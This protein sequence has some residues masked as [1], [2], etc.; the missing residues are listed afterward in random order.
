MERK[1]EKCISNLIDQEKDEHYKSI[2]EK[3][4]NAYKNGKNIDLQDIF[5]YLSKR[6]GVEVSC[7]SVNEIITLLTLYTLDTTYFCNRRVPAEINVYLRKDFL[8][9]T[10]S[11][12]ADLTSVIEE[13]IMGAK[14]EE[15][16]NKLSGED[17]ISTV[18]SGWIDTYDALVHISEKHGIFD[19]VYFAKLLN[20]Y[21][22][23][24]GSKNV[25]LFKDKE[26]VLNMFYEKQNY[27]TYSDD[28][29]RINKRL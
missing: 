28:D 9:E 3:L 16:A 18:L 26:E 17:F 20:D 7:D 4:L 5:N 27:V 15:E 10:F 8:E 11:D 13:E 12:I 21:R 19:A 25:C 14:T 23:S 24:Y 6:V 22:A 2:I 29:A 1:I